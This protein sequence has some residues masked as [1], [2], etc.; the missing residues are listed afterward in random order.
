MK[1]YETV[2]NDFYNKIKKELKSDLGKYY[3]SQFMELAKHILRGKTENELIG[4]LEN[5]MIISYYFWVSELKDKPSP[6]VNTIEDYALLKHLEL[7]SYLSDVFHDLRSTK[8]SRVIRLDNLHLREYS[9]ILKTALIKNQSIY[10]T[11]KEYCEHNNLLREDS[12]DELLRKINYQINNNPIFE[13]YNTFKDKLKTGKIK[14]IA[15]I[16]GTTANL[17]KK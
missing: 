16:I 15:D 4:I 6:G 12:I 2:F 3:Q 17:P 11:V 10:K 14:K 5:K 13:W 7:V 1:K 9:R 8:K